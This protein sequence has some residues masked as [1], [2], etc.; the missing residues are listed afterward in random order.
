[1]KRLI[2]GFCIII[3]A[4]SSNTSCPQGG[5]LSS[6]VGCQTFDAMLANVSSASLSSS[7]SDVP[8]V[9]LMPATSS[10]SELLVSPTQPSLAPAA[11]SVLSIPSSSNIFSAPSFSQDFFIP[12]SSSFESVPTTT[13]TS[14]LSNS[15][16][17]TGSLGSV[18]LPSQFN[19]SLP[20][21]LGV[22]PGADP[23][24][25]SVG[26]PEAGSVLMIGSG[27]IFLSLVS[28]AIRKKKRL[29]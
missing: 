13:F 16:G 26:S 15:L 17:T 29:S 18:I 7:S 27:L 21:G 2:L 5:Q 11:E 28:T 25:G 19:V 3:P 1:M 22:S 14:S 4:F 12:P 8:T 20:F 23:I 6:I 10:F 9:S 24:G